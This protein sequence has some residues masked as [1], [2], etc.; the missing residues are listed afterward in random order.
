M[1][2]G[3]AG[4]VVITDVVITGA[5][6]TGKGAGVDVT[7]NATAAVVITGGADVVI[8]GGACTAG[9]ALIAFLA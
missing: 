7:G 6:I 4:V 2:A 9:C 5:V 3:T 8:T 1:F